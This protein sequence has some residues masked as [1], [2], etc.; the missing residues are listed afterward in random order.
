MLIGGKWLRLS[1]RQ[2]SATLGEAA[3]AREEIRSAFPPRRSS[4]EGE[5]VFYSGATGTH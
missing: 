5:H 3:A 2:E 4:A 1:H